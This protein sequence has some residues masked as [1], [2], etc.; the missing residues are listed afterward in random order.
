MHWVDLTYLIMPNV[1]GVTAPLVLAHVAGW[2]GM[3]LIFLSLFLWRVGETP[4][5]AIKDPWLPDS[6]AYHNL[7]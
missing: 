3:V 7:P 6:L 5:V 2:L 1:G 4:V